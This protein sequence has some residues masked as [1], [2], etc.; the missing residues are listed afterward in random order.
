MNPGGLD[1]VKP[2]CYFAPDRRE[3]SAVGGSVHFLLSGK[4]LNLLIN[5]LGVS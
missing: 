1:E 2:P 5:P 3:L 4:P